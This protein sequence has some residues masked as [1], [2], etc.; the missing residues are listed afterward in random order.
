MSSS[1]QVQEDIANIYL[2]NVEILP[3]FSFYKSLKMTITKPTL[4]EDG[5]NILENRSTKDEIT[6]GTSEGP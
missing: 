1:F 2:L 3:H 4:R 6:K 5:K